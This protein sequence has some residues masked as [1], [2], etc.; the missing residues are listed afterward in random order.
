MADRPVFILGLGAEK[1]GTTWL[2]A[3]LWRHPQIAFCPAELHVWAIRYLQL[4]VDTH[5]H[6]AR[7]RLPVV[8]AT[9]ER[10]P[11]GGS[12][13]A[14][15]S[16]EIEGQAT[17]DALRR[18]PGLYASYFRELLDADPGLRAVGE[19]SPSYALLDRD[20]YR[21][22]RG[23]LED[24]GFDVSPVFIMR[25]PI[26]RIV[27][28]YRYWLW[29]TDPTRS[30]PTTPSLLAYAKRVRN[31]RLTTYEITIDAAIAAFGEDTCF[32]GLYE[33]ITRPGGLDPLYMHLGVD[34]MPADTGNRV[35]E[36]QVRMDPTPDE[37]TALRGLFA[38]TY[39]AVMARFG[40]QR[41]Q[42]AWRNA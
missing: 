16:A 29:Q 11:S 39:D 19:K 31:R 25:D 20:H 37:I 30:L 33:E 2:S 3:E 27:S 41:I 13:R 34:P 5:H 42:E 9:I 23:V 36:T 18:D 14:L 1:S 12:E 22:I 21:E 38:S 15:R 7:N 6:I 26:D 32:F 24:A 28:R 17:F 8:R 4:D 10:A 40:A 35:F